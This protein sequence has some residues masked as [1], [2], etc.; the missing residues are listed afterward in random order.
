MTKIERFEPLRF[1]CGVCQRPPPPLPSERR[2]RQAWTRICCARS[3]SRARPFSI[4]TH[5]HPH[6]LTYYQKWKEIER[7]WEREGWQHSVCEPCRFLRFSFYSFIAPILVYV[8]TLSLYRY[9]YIVKN[10]HRE[11]SALATELPED[12]GFLRGACFAN[13]KGSVGLILAKAWTFYLR[14][15]PFLNLLQKNFQK[16]FSFLHTTVIFKKRSFF[17]SLDGDHMMYISFV[18]SSRFLDS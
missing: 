13:I 14:I 7:D 5:T 8:F 1:V 2:T 12:S 17:Y 9:S 10:A 4:H 18:F 3:L 11:A 16:R 6:T 15:S